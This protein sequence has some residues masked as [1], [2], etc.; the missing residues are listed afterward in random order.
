M[1][2]KD[3]L[4]DK[5]AEENFKNGKDDECFQFHGNAGENWRC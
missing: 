3:E 4:H 1:I 2:F 5:A